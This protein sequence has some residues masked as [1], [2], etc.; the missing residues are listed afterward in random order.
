MDIEINKAE[1]DA[2]DAGTR[3]KITDVITGNFKGS[4]I[5]PS[6]SAPTFSQRAGAAPLGNPFCEAACNIAENAAK[7]ACLGLGD[8]LS[9][10]ACI[11]LAEEAGKECRRRC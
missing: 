4:R 3:K 6:P 9:I 5:V 8:P 10:A 2:L 11:A 1:W 7:A